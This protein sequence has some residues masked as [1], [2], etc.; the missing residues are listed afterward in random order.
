MRGNYKQIP[1]L[2]TTAD[3]EKI[4]D[5]NNIRLVVLAI[6]KS[7]Q[8][9]LENMIDRL[10]EKDVEVKNLPDT[11]DLLS[12]S[13]KTSN[14]MGAALIDLQTGLMPQPGLYSICH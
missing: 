7:K 10:G 11:L 14:V 2:G 13:V 5:R 8:S 1:L 9:L 12:G 6:D 4:I 3:L